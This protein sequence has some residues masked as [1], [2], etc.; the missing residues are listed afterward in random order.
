MWNRKSMTHW[1]VAPC[2]TSH[3][4]R[5]LPHKRPDENRIHWNVFSSCFLQQRV[6]YSTA[7]V[8]TQPTTR[9]AERNVRMTFE[10]LLEQSTRIVAL[11]AVCDCSPPKSIRFV[12][13][14]SLHR[15]ILQDAW[16][17][18]LDL[19]EHQR[20]AL[21][22]VALCMSSASDRWTSPLLVLLLSMMRMKHKLHGLVPRRQFVLD[23]GEKK[24]VVIPWFVSTSADY[25]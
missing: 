20:A 12:K 11:N 22:A 5:D 4:L 25:F 9:R 18:F 2:H 1:L 17:D 15:T 14:N 8:D 16:F 24:G 21:V 7:G 19:R 3:W 6:N 10:T 23:P 13:L